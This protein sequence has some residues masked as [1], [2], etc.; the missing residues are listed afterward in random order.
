MAKLLFNKG[1][2]SALQAKI[3]NG[4]TFTDGAL[5]LTTDEGSLYLGNG[6]KS[7]TRIQGS[8]LFFESL[9]AFTNETKPPYSTDVIYFIAKSNALVRWNGE[10]WIQLNETADGVKAIVTELQGKIDELSGK[11]T[12]AEGK[13]NTLTENLASLTTEV[14]TKATAAALTEEV[15]RAKAAEKAL[16]DDVAAL[17]T[18]DTDIKA[19]IKTNADAIGVL[20]TTVAANAKAISNETAAREAAIKT[21]TDGKVDQ[22]AYDK[23]VDELTKSIASAASAASN[24]QDSADA[25]SGAAAN[26]QSAAT[27]AQNTADAAAKAA[28]DEKTRAT[29]AEAALQTAIEAE[30]ER[31]QGQEGTLSAAIDTKL[32][33]AG[34]TM[35]GNL[36]MGNHKITGLKAPEVDTDAA[37]KKYVDDKVI[38]IN[39]AASDLEERVAAVE[40]KASNNASGIS[41]NKTAIDGLTTTVSSQGTR[42]ATAEANI[43]ANVN[44]IAEKVDKTAYATDKAGLEADIETAQKAAD[45]AQQA[46]DGV[47]ARTAT[48]EKNSATKTELSTAQKALEEKITAAS[49]AAAAAQETATTANGKADANT[50]AISTLGDTLDVYK[51][52]V[53]KG[54][55]K[56][57]G[58]NAMTGALKMGGKQINNV[59]DPTAAQDAATK[60]YVDN[61]M[62]TADAMTFKGVLGTNP[63]T[64]P[65]GEVNKGD[66]YKVGVAG[67]YAGIVAKVGDLFIYNGADT[68]KAVAASWVHVSSGYEDDYLQKLRVKTDENKIYLTDGIND[69]ITG[70]QGSFSIKSNNDN[71]TI[72]VSSDGVITA[73]LVW[74]T[75]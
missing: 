34:D 66:T 44:S 54:Y 9:E 3:A 53:S 13:I 61:A 67:T 73:D 46:A 15:S 1:T 17:K 20:Q 58:S 57:D 64:L 52:E 69:D 28:A 38:E 12:T 14:G 42:L 30:A 59:A 68:D 48:L 62:K 43:K 40:T 74:G 32:S 37:N 45:A 55:V 65:T 75:F 36:A 24:A 2:Y 39:S 10:K 35:G 72:T 26:A 18:A 33:K 47:A 7:L 21:L 25:A 49:E 5:Y 11:V 6:S 16:T 63:L 4:D 71:L 70:A 60:A 22:T 19:S 23:K 8:V 41:S 27:K 56:V 50:K 31:A 29:G 51:S